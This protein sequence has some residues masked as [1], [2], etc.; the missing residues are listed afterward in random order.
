MVLRV[1]ALLL[2]EQLHR[3]HV[4]RRRQPG[5]RRPVHQERA[6]PADLAD[7]AEDEVLGLLR[8]DRQVPRPRH[9]ERLRSRDR[10]LR[11]VLAGLSHQPGQADVHADEPAARRRRLLEQPRVL[12][13]QLP[14]RHRAAARH[15]GVV[16]QRS[17]RSKQDIE[18]CARKD[19]RS[20]DDAEPARYT[21]QA[22]GVVRD[23]LAQHQGR[24]PADVGHLLP[25][26]PT[27][28]ATS[29]R[30]TRAA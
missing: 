14:G 30:S 4:Q 3:R 26:A 28:T 16:R 13:E 20:A 25:H 7:H 19:A 2:G 9:A 21:V 5:R 6:G 24:L 8:R 22:I 29:T 18:G 10:G 15:A 17:R 12:H 1:G 27:R 11:V 23:R